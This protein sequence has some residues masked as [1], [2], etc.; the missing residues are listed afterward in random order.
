MGSVTSSGALTFVLLRGA[1]TILSD[2]KVR[3]IF[4]PVCF[5]YIVIIY[6]Y[7]DLDAYSNIKLQALVF[8]YEIHYELNLR[9]NRF[10][11]K[12]RLSKIRPFGIVEFHHIIIFFSCLFIFFL[13]DLFRLIKFEKKAFSLFVG[14]I[15]PRICLHR[16]TNRAIFS[17]HP[18]TAKIMQMVSSL[19]KA[20]SNVPSY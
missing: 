16:S 14:T 12:T 6:I 7:T 19:R 9:S 4:W 11:K 18:E 2:S 3:P 5:I 20:V 13:L 15:K 10:I 17:Q 8:Q 1:K